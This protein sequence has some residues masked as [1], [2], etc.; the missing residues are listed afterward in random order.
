MSRSASSYSRTQ[1]INRRVP[2]T[3]MSQWRIKTWDQLPEDLKQQLKKLPPYLTTRR[4]AE[5]NGGS[6]SK[7][8]EH[9]EAGY[10]RAFKDDGTTLWETASILIRLANLPPAASNHLPRPFEPDP[11]DLAELMAEAEERQATIGRNTATE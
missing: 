7:L 8:Y 10:I 2:A 6:P 1:G 9:K 4:A 5:L 11:D 3:P